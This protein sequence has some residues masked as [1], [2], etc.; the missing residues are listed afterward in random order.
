MLLRFLIDPS[1]FTLDFILAKF[2][3][4]L[5]VNVYLE[6]LQTIIGQC[7]WLS[8]VVLSWDIKW[9]FDGIILV[10]WN[11]HN[12]ILFIKIKVITV[13]RI[14]DE[15]WI[16]LSILNYESYAFIKF[17]MSSIIIWRSI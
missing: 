9:K 12:V 7:D 4:S 10:V 11:V 15:S 5:I 2:V 14:H 8:V 1:R 13:E 6:T 16:R 17:I 3:Q